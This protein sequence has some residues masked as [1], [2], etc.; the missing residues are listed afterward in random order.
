MR[1]EVTR[2]QDTAIKWRQWQSGQQVREKQSK[3]IWL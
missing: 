2:L 3:N 1:G